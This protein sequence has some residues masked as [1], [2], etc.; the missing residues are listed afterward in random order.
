LN[1]EFEQFIKLFFRKYGSGILN[2]PSKC[3][4][5]LKDWAKGEYQSELGLFRQLAELGYCRN[6]L[7]TK[8]PEIT[9]NNLIR[10]LQNENYLTEE[11]SYSIIALLFM[12][13]RNYRVQKPAAR[14]AAKPV[15]HNVPP[16]TVP[17]VK[18]QSQK[19]RG[20]I[21]PEKIKQAYIHARL[22]YNGNLTMAQAVTPL[23]DNYGWNR[24]S[25]LMYITGIRCLFEGR[26][27]GKDM[28]REAIEY[29]LG[30]IQRE[31]GRDGLIRALNALMQRIQYLE[32]NNFP[33]HAASVRRIYEAW[34]NR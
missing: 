5:L 16:K 7:E 18:R 32:N 2:Q 27:Y 3:M 15:S 4:G 31:Y 20:K 22:V 30:Q 14:P 13:L 28:S 10:R 11:A 26:G 21:T 9:A 25:A 8:E 19:P 6:I 24:A 33:S 1:Q 23:V 34:V 29:F 12:V 17:P